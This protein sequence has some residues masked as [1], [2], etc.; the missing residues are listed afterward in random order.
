VL[1]CSVASFTVTTHCLCTSC[2]ARCGLSR[3]AGV[4]EQYDGGCGAG[5]AEVVVQSCY[6]LVLGLYCTH[7]RMVNVLAVHSSLN[8]GIY[9]YFMKAGG[10]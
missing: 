5:R 2:L 4:D 1:A 3:L 9:E 10:A 6:L 8:G 7:L